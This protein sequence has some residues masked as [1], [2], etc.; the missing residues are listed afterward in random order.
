[1]AARSI[2]L[3]IRNS[4]GQTTNGSRWTAPGMANLCGLRASVGRGTPD[5]RFVCALAGNR[6]MGLELQLA[7]LPRLDFLK[8]LDNLLANIPIAHVNSSISFTIRLA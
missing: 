8:T 3:V 1:M 5:S 2:Y 7:T 6:L 4:W